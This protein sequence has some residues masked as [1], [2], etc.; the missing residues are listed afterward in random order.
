MVDCRV[1]SNSNFKNLYHLCEKYDFW[2]CFLH[3]HIFFFSFTAEAK[4]I[5]KRFVNHKLL[6]LWREIGR[7][8]A[9]FFGNFDGKE[10][11]QKIRFPAPKQEIPN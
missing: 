10:L 3:V 2:E 4:K 8:S 1:R 11:F 5:K 6:R 7:K 9:I